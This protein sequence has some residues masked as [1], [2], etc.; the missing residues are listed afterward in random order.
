[1]F[2]NLVN[3]QRLLTLLLSLPKPILLAKPVG[4]WQSEA[5][6]VK[7]VYLPINKVFKLFKLVLQ[8]KLIKLNSK[9]HQ[10]FNWKNFTLIL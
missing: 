1:M 4:Q 2:L 10:I 5:R 6:F 9:Q 3:N 8:A 7:K